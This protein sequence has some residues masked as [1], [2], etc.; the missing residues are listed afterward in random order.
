MPN[1]LFTLTLTLKV[2]LNILLFICRYTHS[3]KHYSIVYLG[4]KNLILQHIFPVLGM[5]IG[6]F[7]YSAY[8]KVM[9]YYVLSTESKR[10]FELKDNISIFCIQ[11]NNIEYYK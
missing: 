1:I 7:T 2:K 6:P 8:L 5:N 9:I 3:C 4:K 10:H 11:I